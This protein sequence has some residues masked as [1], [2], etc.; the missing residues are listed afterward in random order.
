[1]ERLLTADVESLLAGMTDAYPLWSFLLSTVNL[2][3][4]YVEYQYHFS[5]ITEFIRSDLSLLCANG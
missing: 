2:N 4:I 5:S 1:V 3:L